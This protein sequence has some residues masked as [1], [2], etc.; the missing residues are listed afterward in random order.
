MT[1]SG[2][3]AV[4]GALTGGAVDGL[5]YQGPRC[6]N[7]SR[8]VRAG[9][10]SFGQL[11]GWISHGIGEAGA[12]FYILSALSTVSNWPYEHCS[13]LQRSILIWVIIIYNNNNRLN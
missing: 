1:R 7:V 10:E 2:G 9:E 4:R 5:V 8:K 13:F 12:F 3:Y 6:K 11:R